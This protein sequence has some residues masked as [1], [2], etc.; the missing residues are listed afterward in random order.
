[1]CVDV[2]GRHHQFSSASEAIEDRK[3]NT[4]A[5]TYAAWELLAAAGTLPDVSLTAVLRQG[6]RPTAELVDQYRLR[7]RPIRDL[8]VRYLDERRPSMD[9][10]SFRGLVI[11]LVK[12]FWADLERHH[13][14]ID[15]I[16]LPED[17]AQAWKQRL[18]LVTDRDGTT[19]QRRSR[20]D[21][22]G[23]VR[24]FYLDIAEWALQDP[25]WAPWAVPCPIRTA[26]TDGQVKERKQVVAAMHQRVR[27]RLPQLPVLVDTAERHRTEQAA[28]LRAAAAVDIGQTFDHAGDCYRRVAK[29]RT[30]KGIRGGTPVVLVEN[31]ATGQR[32][33]LVRAEDD[34]FWAWAIIEV[35]RHT[36]I[37]HEEFQEIT[38]LALVSYR[39][40]DTGELIPLLQ[41]VPSKNNEERL[42]LVS[43]ELA[44]V[45][46]TIITRLR[47]RNDGT[48]P[49]VTLYDIH[50]RV[51]GPPLPHLFQRKV[52]WRNEVINRNT[53]GD[54]LRATLNRTGL[55]DAAGA[56]L[57]Y[58]PHDFRRM[59]ATDA[60]TGGLKRPSFRAALMWAASRA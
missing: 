7:C 58:T 40:P 46:A 50:E 48:I 47:N 17:V 26:D 35:L 56:P 22:L 4:P 13:P 57:H 45:L 49:P 34:A 24:G 11:Y 30:E 3:P 20:L 9:H 59:F 10:T 25:S 33:E 36:G 39:L 41:I 54:L 55:R 15:S 21:L 51:T 8:L 16:D 5:G 28:L 32:T 60:V 23:R 31:T 38:H 18:F 42:L 1:V 27:E 29:T 37:R 44:S 12:N 52:G 53:V 6:Q 14:G 2:T 19:R 43:P